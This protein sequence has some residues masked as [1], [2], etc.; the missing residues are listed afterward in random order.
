MWLR[1]ASIEQ[2]MSRLHRKTCID[3]THNIWA[4]RAL[5]W[6][7]AALASPGPPLTQRLDSVGNPLIDDLC[8][9]FWGSSPEFLLTFAAHFRGMEPR[10]RNSE[11]RQTVVELDSWLIYLSRPYDGICDLALV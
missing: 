10:A 9:V 11:F 5:P 4:S 2:R 1:G 6:D 3:V 8:I 7:S